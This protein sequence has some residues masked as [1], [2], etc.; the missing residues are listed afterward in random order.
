MAKVASTADSA[1]STADNAV[2]AVAEGSTIDD[3]TRRAAATRRGA[4]TVRSSS[5]TS[6]APG[7]PAVS[8]LRRDDA[9]CRQTDVASRAA[10]M[11]P[12]VPTAAGVPR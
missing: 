9:R 8:S 10:A 3:G 4:L 2:D 7:P 12:K 5:A 1:A 11:A 6:S